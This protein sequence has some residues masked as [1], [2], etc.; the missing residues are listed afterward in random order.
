MADLPGDVIEKILGFL[1]RPD[2][3]NVHVNLL[4]FGSTC[5]SWRA[6]VDEDAPAWHDALLHRFGAVVGP[7]KGPRDRRAPRSPFED[8][9]Y[10]LLVLDLSGYKQGVYR[11]RDSTWRTT[12]FSAICLFAISGEWLDRGNA[13]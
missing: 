2:V 10:A 12:S 9:S 11:A 3:E 1:T 4:A 6:A 8:E 5:K 7:S 13:S